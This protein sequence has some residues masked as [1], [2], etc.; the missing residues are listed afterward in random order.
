MIGTEKTQ[1]VTILKKNE[2]LYNITGGIYTL[3]P[4]H[5]FT[6]L[7]KNKLIDRME[8]LVQGNKKQCNAYEFRK[9]ETVGLK[10]PEYD[11]CMILAYGL[12]GYPLRSFCDKHYDATSIA[13]WSKAEAVSNGY[14]DQKY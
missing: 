13:V 4:L 5:F 2:L 12:A 14:L 11:E 9:C 7:N 1:E 8:C 10:V 6:T 3:M